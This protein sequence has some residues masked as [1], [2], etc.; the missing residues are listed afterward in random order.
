MDVSE[1][2]NCS[3]HDSA[4]G[5]RYSTSEVTHKAATT[6]GPTNVVPV[7]TRVMNQ[8]LCKLSNRGPIKENRIK[9]NASIV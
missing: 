3:D 1:R 6:Q 7:G 5:H 2:N 4:H 9:P 8:A